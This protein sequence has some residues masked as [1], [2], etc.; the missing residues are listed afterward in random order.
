[1]SEV[2]GRPGKALTCGGFRGTA[3]ERPIREHNEEE[4]MAGG[5]L[6]RDATPLPACED[7]AGR[8]V[9]DTNARGA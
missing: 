2:S 3:R 7:P 4:R 5:T 8:G 1:M 6:M 9:I